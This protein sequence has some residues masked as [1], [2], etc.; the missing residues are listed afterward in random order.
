MTLK[1]VMTV[2][3]LETF[4]ER[5]FPEMH[6]GGKVFFV[7]EVRPG[8]IVMRFAADERHLRPGGTVSGPAQFALADVASYVAVLAHTGPVA[9]AVTTS[10]SINFL[11]KPPLGDLLA[12]ARVLKLGRRLVV[13][14]CAIAGAGDGHVVAHAVATYSLPNSRDQNPTTGGERAR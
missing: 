13:I 2:D 8:E 14:D 7:E 12:T 1:T 5:E 11:R 4:L 9:L 10:A 6:V 3:E